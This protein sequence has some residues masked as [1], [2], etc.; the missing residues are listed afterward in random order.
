MK[1]FFLWL[2]ARLWKGGGNEVPAPQPEQA[3]IPDEVPLPSG[4]LPSSGEGD[5]VPAHHGQAPEREESEK[6]SPKGQKLARKRLSFRRQSALPKPETRKK[7]PVLKEDA[8]LF[9][10]MGG[11]PLK[12]GDVKEPDLPEAEILGEQKEGKGTVLWSVPTKTLDLHGLTLQQA[13]IRIRS[14]LLTARMEGVKVM[15]IVT[16]K[17]LHSRSGK[18]ILRDHTDSLLLDFQKN[19]EIRAFRWE[20]KT[21]KKS[22]A[23][24]VR[25]R[26]VYT[27]VE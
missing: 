15:R 25:L 14:A 11:D 13:D 22:G 20:G 17:G 1:R 4:E 5:P 2:R 3:Q 27:E 18:A 21:L 6:T 16:G 23:V 26:E 9:V 12:A 8:D 24:Q 19:G 10:L 7:I